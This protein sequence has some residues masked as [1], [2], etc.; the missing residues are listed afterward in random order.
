M[1][2]GAMPS[3]SF[4]SSALLKYLRERFAIN[5]N[6]HHGAPHWAR[7]RLNGLELAG[8][9]GANAHVVELFAFFHDSCRVNEHTDPGH[10]QRGGELA[11]AL[12]GRFFEASD[13]EM[14]WLVSAC[15]GHSDGGLLADITVQV[16]WDADRLDLSR[17]GIAPKARYLCT[18][19]ARD[20]GMIDRATGRAE[21][22][23]AGR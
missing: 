15:N 9:C 5:W 7:V 17:V 20:Q 13:Q 22:W 6:G 23:L 16:C 4:E 11:V 19:Q 14:E 8:P 1:E 12:R 10:G 21:A 18:P 2:N 3:P